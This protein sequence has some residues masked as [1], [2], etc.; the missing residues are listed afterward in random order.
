MFRL[1]VMALRFVTQTPS[2]AMNGM[3]LEWWVFETVP[4]RLSTTCKLWL[5]KVILQT[6]WGWRCV[7][8]PTTVLHSFP[9]M[10]I[11]KRLMVDGGR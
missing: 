1:V 3:F 6:I 10:R 9:M 8:D 4:D 5:S 11:C 7:Q 2:P